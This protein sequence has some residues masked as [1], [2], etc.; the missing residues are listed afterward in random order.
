MKT[1]HAAD[2]QEAAV[3]LFVVFLFFLSSEFLHSYSDVCK[4]LNTSCNM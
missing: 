3:L 1:Q 2:K 4:Q